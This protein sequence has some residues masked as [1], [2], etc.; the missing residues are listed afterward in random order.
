MALYGRSSRILIQNILRKR[1][2]ALLKQCLSTSRPVLART[3][4]EITEYVKKIEAKHWTSYGYDEDN[5]K[6]DKLMMNFAC[7]LFMF[8]FAYGSFWLYYLPDYKYRDWSLRE[9]YIV[10]NQRERAG[11]PPV[12]KNF[13]DPALIELPSDEEL[14]DTKVYI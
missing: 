5:Q 4:E 7:F 2:P 13:I 1:H 8:I 12:D 10:L 6:Q 11:L 14:G 9:A 3:D